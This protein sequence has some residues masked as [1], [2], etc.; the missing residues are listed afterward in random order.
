MLKELKNTIR[1]TAIYGFGNVAVK[2]IGF[3]L[4]PLYTKHISVP[5]YGILGILEVTILIL[6]Q[7]LIF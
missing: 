2:L 5:E 7:V 3:V 4:M 6:S 1:H